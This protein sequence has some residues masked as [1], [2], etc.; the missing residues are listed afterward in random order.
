[1]LHRA[2]R[3]ATL[4]SLAALVLV[5]TALLVPGLPV[6]PGP[7]A[8]Q[9]RDA[10]SEL[11]NPDAERRLVALQ[12]LATSPPSEGKPDRA[13]LRRVERMLLKDPD[14]R[15]RAAAAPA[16]ARAGGAAAAAPLL[17][18]L[19]RELEPAVAESVMRAF[20][21]I[22]ADS[23]RRPLSEL[24]FDP[25]DPRVGCLAA[26]ALGQ[27]A[28]EAGSAD[29]RAL[30]RSAPHWAVLAG[31][32][33]GL[34][35]TRQPEAV[36]DLVIR[37]RHPDAAVRSAARDALILL[38][39][40]DHGIDPRAWEEWWEAKR[41]GFAFP[42][43]P[44]SPAGSPLGRADGTTSDDWTAGDRPTFSRFFGIPLR[45]RRVCLV[46]DYSQSMWGPRRDKAEEEL[47]D[48]V[49][50][51][52]SAASFAVI[53]F[54][55]KV[56]WFGDGPL[57]ARPQ[58]KFDLAGYLPEQETK[59]YTNIYDSLERALGLRGVG[60]QARDPAPGVD[61]IVV[62]SDGV[63]NRGKLK[64]TERIL[65]AVEALNGGRV[66]IHTVSLGD[67]ELDLLPAL[68]ERN[69]G[70]HVRHPFPK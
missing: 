66:R 36:D 23:A 58:H 4:L 70:K 60:T 35:R 27:L 61:E 38:C 1:M 34:A 47:L 3:F 26:E 51:L 30:L 46:V 69:G 20:A 22:P 59:S 7:A 18:A 48:A 50:G 5:L 41:E 14:G 12:E 32:C 42:E 39:G 9:S 37:L 25:A 13:L 43:L 55:E 64:D 53:L 49:K 57:P 56:W 63:P 45:G 19:G 62:L 67:E 65:E 15:V 31:A 6:R 44:G 40:V 29:L 54:N 21:F 16:L 24:A 17:A 2:V 10:A 52:S 11:R 33:L 8:A 28:G 68:A